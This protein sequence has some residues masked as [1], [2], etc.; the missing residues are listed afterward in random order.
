MELLHYQDLAMLPQVVFLQIPLVLV[1]KQ[2]VV[3]VGLG[4]ANL[5]VQDSCLEVEKVETCLLVLVQDLLVVAVELLH[6]QNL[7]MLLQVV[8]LQIPLVHVPKQEV[9]MVALGMAN[10]EVEDL[11]HQVVKVETLHPVQVLDF[12]LVAVDLHFLED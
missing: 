6:P 10:F 3:K 4:M 2:E 12:L 8:F 7:A 1:P 11:C 9:E 5:R